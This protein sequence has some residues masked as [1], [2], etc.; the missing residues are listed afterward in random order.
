MWEATHLQCDVGGGGGIYS[1]MWE[2]THLQ[3]DVGGGHLQCDV[4][5]NAFTL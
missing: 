5:G 2:A 4:G 1:V 3:C